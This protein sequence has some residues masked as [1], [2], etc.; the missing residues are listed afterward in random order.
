MRSPITRTL[1]CKPR[2]WR[3]SPCGCQHRTS[4]CN[5]ERRPELLCSH[6]AQRR[7]VASIKSCF[8][9][10]CTPKNLRQL[11]VVQGLLESQW[12]APRRH[13]FRVVQ[14]DTWKLR[15][16]L[17]PL[18]TVWPCPGHKGSFKRSSSS[19]LG[20]LTGPSSSLLSS[21][22]SSHG[23]AQYAHTTLT[24]FRADSLSTKREKRFPLGQDAMSPGRGSH[25]HPA[26]RMSR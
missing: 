14:G 25:A 20:C 18:Q 6:A 13:M 11:L 12:F 4:R 7:P 15:A 1:W 21:M 2:R 23:D 17:G 22:W 9:V 8:E 24:S 26:S 3:T 10:N 5:E 16:F 19:S